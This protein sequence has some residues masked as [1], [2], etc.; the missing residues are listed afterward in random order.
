MA[1]YTEVSDEALKAFVAQYDIG[2]VAAFK[3]I[4]EGVENSNYLL[5]TDKGSFILTLYEKRVRREDLPF[6]LA[7][8][9]HLAAHGTDCPVPIHGRDGTALR[10]LCGRPAAIATFLHGMWPRRTTPDHCR[11][12]GA[13]LARMHLAGQSFDGSR[14]ND[15]SVDAWRRIFTECA[16]RADSVQPG[17]GKEI[18]AELDI[19]EREWPR[20]IPAGIIHADLFPDNVFFLHNRLSG[21]IDYYFA[22]TDFFAYDLAICLNAWCFEPDRSFNVTKARVMLNAYRAERPFSAAELDALPLLA[23]GSA[24]RFLLTRLYD[25]LHHPEGALVQPKD[26]LEYWQKLRFHRKVTGPAAY[27]LI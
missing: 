26:P 19:L 7:L 3:G 15:L 9:E 18:E 10:E 8:M 5:Q 1:V 12:L 23:R 16:D 14:N 27:G 11:Q 24:M 4:A 21:L 20:D 13:A 17:L 2:E 22:C 6:F 25:W